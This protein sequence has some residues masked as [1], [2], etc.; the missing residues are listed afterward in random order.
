M[1]V[2]VGWG[3][4]GFMWLLAFHFASSAFTVPLWRLFIGFRRLLRL[5]LVASSALPVAFGGWLW[6]FA[7]PVGFLDR[8]DLVAPL[9]ESSL[10]RTTWGTLL[11]K[12]RS[13]TVNVLVVNLCLLNLVTATIVNAAF[14]RQAADHEMVA[15]EQKDRWDWGGLRGLVSLQNYQSYPKTHP[16][17]PSNINS[18][19]TL[20]SL[21]NHHLDKVHQHPSTWRGHG[22]K[23]LLPPVNINQNREHRF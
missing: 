9:F 22:S 2:R 20:V 19:N 5:S 13:E 16:R 15:R 23:P 14:E 8:E 21:Q 11:L 18:A 6:L 1:F 4:R 10:L 12:S 3:V 7:F 17:G